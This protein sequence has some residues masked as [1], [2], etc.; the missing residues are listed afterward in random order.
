MNLPSFTQKLSFRIQLILAAFVIAMA[1]FH[2]LYWQPEM[3][4]R[5]R[6]SITNSVTRNVDTIANAAAP[7]LYAGDLQSMNDVLTSFVEQYNQDRR[8]NSDPE[9]GQLSYSDAGD[10]RVTYLEILGNTGDSKFRFGEPPEN[11]SAESTNLLHVQRE[12]VFVGLSAGIVKAS[13][14]ISTAIAREHS[15]LLWYEELQLAFAFGLAIATA[16][17]LD[18]NVRRPLTLLAK[19]SQ[20]LSQGDYTAQL[21]PPS[22]DEVGVLSS[23]FDR[24]RVELHQR[25]DE[26]ERSR[27]QAESAN[28]AKS[29][30]IANMSHE[31]RTP[32]NSILGMGELLSQTELNPTQKAY[33]SVFS[34]SAKSLLAIINQILDFSKIEVGKLS[35]NEEQFN[36]HELI[37][38]TLKTLSFSPKAQN[39]QIF[40]R[41]GPNTPEFLVGD[42][43]RLKQVLINLVGNAI[44]FTEEG[45]I[46]VDVT[47][48]SSPDRQIK[49]LFSVSDTGRGIPEEQRKII[50]EPFEQA[51]G[52]NTREYGGTGLGLAVSSGIIESAGGKIWVE[53]KLDVG[54]TFHFEWTFKEADIKSIPE[55]QGTNAP[56]DRITVIEP[57]DE[58]RKIML[59]TISQWSDKISGYRRL[60]DASLTAGTV[61]ESSESHLIFVDFTSLSE[62]ERNQLLQQKSNSIHVVGLLADPKGTAFIQN[63]PGIDQ[64]LIKPVKKSEFKCVLERMNIDQSEPNH[65]ENLAFE[66]SPD[67]VGEATSDPDKEL[68]VLV[69]DD[70]ASNRLLVTHLL[71]KMGHQVS[72]AVDGSDAIERWQEEQPDVI[73][74]DIQMPKLDGLEATKRIRELEATEGGHV[75]IIAA[76]AG[77]MIADRNKCIEV[78]MDD[79]I[80]KPIRIN[81]FQKVLKRRPR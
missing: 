28:Q 14:D 7:E 68:S 10:T 40:Y 32:M 80:S 64:I 49:L 37:G 20:S 4:N 13:F 35:L 8:I 31:I 36:L 47:A 81:D 5:L 53:S 2:L 39:L 58:Q 22:K 48:H 57:H 71:K 3:E 61:K 75:T 12:V 60:S 63:L 18:R 23:G 33:V 56:F 74:M 66:K 62:T 77:A 26:L 17:V 45:D 52:S 50:F 55:L 30:F 6:R 25:L 46:R 16:L 34:E 9:T 24:M 70:V 79:Y 67:E 15:W 42:E 11:H 29:Q 78:G 69:A 43:H 27:R 44:K 59:E 38:D 41:L 54:T 72:I 76:T 51:D 65:P 1:A 19:A 21:P 73:L